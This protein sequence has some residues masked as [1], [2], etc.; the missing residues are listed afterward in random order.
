MLLLI[1]AAFGCAQNPRDIPIARGTCF[2]TEDT[3]RMDGSDDEWAWSRAE[4][5][6]L[7]ENN[8]PGANQIPPLKTYVRTLWNENY[9]YVFF[10]CEDHHI[11]VDYRRRDDPLWDAKEGLELVEV[12]L[13]PKQG[14]GRYYEINVN[15]AGVV[16]DVAVNVERG[17]PRFDP[18]WDALGMS[19]A[20]ARR[21]TGVDHF[22]G[23]TVELAI[24]WRSVGC[25]RPDVGVQLR[26]NFHRGEADLAMP[27]LSWSP[28][29][30]ASFHVPKRFGVLT[31]GEN[32]SE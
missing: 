25:S 19:V 21:S 7:V 27:H 9:L 29:V 10:F 15:P 16:L 22:D 18:A 14:A 30:R 24:P 1:A 23:W 8:G 5:L 3:I 6:S 26:A 17:I 12:I 13:M 28:T 32:L 2:R 11:R 4:V 31:L 20:T